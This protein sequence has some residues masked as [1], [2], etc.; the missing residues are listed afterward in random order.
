MDTIIENGL[1]YLSR[2]KRENIEY[3][4][5]RSNKQLELKLDDISEQVLLI[6]DNDRSGAY[7]VIN[8]SRV[9]EMI[10]DKGG[11]TYEL[12]GIINVLS[13]WEFGLVKNR[14]LKNAEQ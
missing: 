2:D 11:F 12:S 1:T 14:Q 4:R 7:F 3:L 13:K 6:M 10:E 5:F 9:V 8:R